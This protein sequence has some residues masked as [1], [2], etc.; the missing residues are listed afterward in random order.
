MTIAAVDV[1]YREGGAQAA[2]VSFDAW[3]DPV[4]AHECVAS[5]PPAAPYVSGEFFLRELPC[6]LE[7]LRRA[8]ARPDTIIVDGY[9]WLDRHGSPGLGAH[10]WRA[11]GG[12]CAVVGVAKN[13]R[14][15]SPDACAIVRGR[16]AKPLFVS[17]VGLPAREAARLVR[18]MHGDFRIPDL[19]RRVD[20]LARGLDAPR[21]GTGS[22]GGGP[23]GP[24]GSLRA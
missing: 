6:L 1:H 23:C 15:G 7:I 17:A 21:R 16:S 19:L 22:G 3:T 9:V 2:C 10:L 13:P 24:V 5:L 11:L 12:G 14:K 4:A 8:P 18:G 20:R